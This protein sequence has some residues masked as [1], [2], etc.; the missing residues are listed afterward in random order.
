MDKREIDDYQISEGF[1]MMFNTCGLIQVC[2]PRA[3]TYS[4]KFIARAVELYLGG[5]AT[6]YIRWVDLENTLVKEFA[7]E[8]E[9]KE[10]PAPETVLEWVR[11]YPDLPQRLRE[12]RVQEAGSTSTVS[13]RPLSAWNY[14]ATRE[15]VPVP[16]ASA[17]SYD[18]NALLNLFAA[19]VAL[20]LLSGFMRALLRD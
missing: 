15:F 18:I 6:R 3:P 10:L 12:L 13:Q 17:G 16:Y 11:K 8:L 5:V 7:G 14:Q 20:A 1:I 19:F 9:G 2:S 4:G